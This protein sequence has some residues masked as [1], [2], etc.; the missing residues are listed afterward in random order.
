MGDNCLELEC[1]RY[2][3]WERGDKNWENITHLNPEA[4]YLCKLRKDVFDLKI[5]K[6]IY[7]VDYD[8]ETGKF[9]EKNLIKPKDNI[10]L[11]GL[12]TLYD[13]NINKHINLKIYVDTQEKL[14]YYWKI[15]RDVF[16]RNHSIEKVI[17]TIEKR[18]DDY[19]NYIQPQKNNANIIINY[20]IDNDID[21]QNI[22]SDINLDLKLN[23]YVKYDLNNFINILHTLDYNFKYIQDYNYLELYL[24]NE[25]INTEKLYKRITNDYNKREF[26]RNGYYGIIQCLIVY[27]I[28]Y[29][30]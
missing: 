29:C 12:H 27:I 16:I 14:K 19:I 2:H 9:T 6:D 10:I 24:D 17:N 23:I 28:L 15:K 7:Q 25:N 13:N 20:Y 11:C 26:I 5:G 22:D 1:D 18:K 30:Q 4:N 8:H 3:K 21:I